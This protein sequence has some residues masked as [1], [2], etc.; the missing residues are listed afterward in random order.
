MRR[1][2]PSRRAARRGA[3]DFVETQVRA[4]RAVRAVM[5]HAEA[6]DFVLDPGLDFLRERAP[7]PCRSGEIGAPI[8]IVI[9]PGRL[10]N[11]PFGH[12]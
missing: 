1:T 3:A 10:P 2:W 4:R 7:G 5:R 9:V 6:R 8:V 11:R 12:T